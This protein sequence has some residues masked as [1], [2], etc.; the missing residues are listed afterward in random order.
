MDLI[1]IWNSLH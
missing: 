1:H